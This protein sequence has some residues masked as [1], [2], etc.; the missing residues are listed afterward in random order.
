[1]IL[2]FLKQS[3]RLGSIGLVLAILALGLLLFLLR[4]TRR[5]VGLY[6]AAAFGALWTLATPACAERLAASLD[7]R[8]RPLARIE[9]ARGANTIVV[10]GAGSSTFHVGALAVTEPSPPAIFRVVEAARLYRMLDHP[11]VIMSGGPTDRHPGAAPESEALR[12]MAVRLGIPPERIELESRSLNTRDEAVEIDRMLPDRPRRPFILVT[13]PTHM[14]RSMS[15]FRAVGLDPI[16]SPSALTSDGSFESGRWLPNDVALALSD[17]AIYEWLAWFY[18][19]WN[20]WL[21]K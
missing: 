16:P 13:S 17:N 4:R 6:F 3:M 12:D 15:V 5:W 21:A 8:D 19:G 20:G 7:T 14:R 11:V 1:M 2:D 9:D 10:L 18:Y